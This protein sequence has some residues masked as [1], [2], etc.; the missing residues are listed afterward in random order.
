MFPVHNLH[1]V[2][3]ETLEQLGT[4]AKFW[5][6]HPEW[7]EQPV[8][9][10]F[11]RENSGEDWAEKVCCELCEFLGIPHAQYELANCPNGLLGLSTRG[12]L[13]PNFVPQSGRLVLGNELLGK[14][15]H[16]YDDH[17]RKYKQRLHT[18][19]R[20]FHACEIHGVEPPR[21]SYRLPDGVQSP[22]DVFTG[23]LMLD[24]LVGNQDRHHENWAL[25]ITPERRI[26]LAP[27]YDHASSLGRNET[28]ATRTQRLET[29]DTGFGVDKYITKARSALYLND[30]SPKP[31]TTFEAFQLAFNQYPVAAEAWLGR[32]A[33]LTESDVS[34]IFRQI[35]RDI[36]SETGAVF[37]SKIIELNR[38]RLLTLI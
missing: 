24:A 13:T 32:L 3:Q 9:F 19:R 11:N 34:S 30:A 5:F 12:I 21:E 28:D 29:K 6:Y 36:I 33:K 23:Y 4:K 14:N 2:T 26:H 25:L 8:L 10:K 31:L 22:A 7:P 15:T 16:A 1:D 17:G 20:V 38:N 18:L 27:T 35:P 37:A